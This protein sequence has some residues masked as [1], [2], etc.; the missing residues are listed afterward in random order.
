ME[1]AWHHSEWAEHQSTTPSQPFSTHRPDIFG[2]GT[3]Q[4]LGLSLQLLNH[5]ALESLGSS[6]YTGQVSNSHHSF[7]RA[8]SVPVEQLREE[9]LWP[10]QQSDYSGQEQPQLSLLHRDSW[11]SSSTDVRPSTETH[12]SPTEETHSIPQPVILPPVGKR[13]RGRPRIYATPPYGLGSDLPYNLASDSGKSQLEKNRIAAEKSRR[14]RKEHTNG[15]MASVSALSSKNETLKAEASVLR[16]ELLN[17]KSEVLCHAGCNS[18]IIDGYIARIAG[19]KLV[20]VAPKH[21]LSRKDSGHTLSPARS[22]K[23]LSAVAW[24][25]SQAPP[26]FL[27]PNTHH[28]THS[29]HLFE[30]IDEFL[31]AEA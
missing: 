23:S 11:Q 14:R 29:C 5:T 10:Q 17:I 26:S 21:T 2:S 4:T 19:S 3:E 15:L 12:Y 30:L 9:V 16:E 28:I 25:G 24:K 18:S 8:G 31:D 20:E 7:G 1:L 13:K 6:N 27:E 22:D